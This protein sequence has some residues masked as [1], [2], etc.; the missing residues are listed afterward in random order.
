MAAAHL[1]VL[2]L[3]LLSGCAQL[4]P[5]VSEQ[6]GIFQHWI[7]GTDR[8]EPRTQTQRYDADTFV[9]RQSV[10]TNPEGPF[11]YLLFGRDRALLLD[12]GAGGLTIRPSV[13]AA[14][15]QWL[16]ERQRASIPLI[17]AHSHGHGDHQAGDH[18]FRARPDTQVVGVQPADVAAFFGIAEWP[19][20][21]V[22]YDLG[23]RV[24][25]IIPTPGHHPSHIMIYDERTKLLLSGDALYPGRL[26]IPS[27]LLGDFQASTDRV[28]EFLKGRDVSHIL[29]AHIEMT[30]TPGVDIKLGASQHPNEHVLELAPEQL[31]ELQAAVRAMGSTVVRE[32]HDDFIVFPQPP[33]PPPAATP[34]N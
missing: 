24:L 21:I 5:R 19:N 23:D 3:V 25:R 1:P 12:T 30:R 10:R 16:A 13:D 14:I 29:G 8:S 28:V 33:R 26:Y 2:A 4:P 11:L 31:V 34:P 27:N 15:D 22:K 6:R 32:V 18:E 17:V 9:I 7:D 20:S